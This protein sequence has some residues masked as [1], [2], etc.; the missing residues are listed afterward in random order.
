MEASNHIYVKLGV[1]LMFFI[2]IFYYLSL[3]MNHFGLHK[4]LKTFYKT[5][6]RSQILDMFIPITTTVSLNSTINIT[7]NTTAGKN[8]TSST[9]ISTTTTTG[10]TT[11][12]TT[13]GRPTTID[14]A[15]LL[16]ERL[17]PTSRLTSSDSKGTIAVFL[18]QTQH[19]VLA[20]LQLYL[21]RKFAV[22]LVGLELFL[23]GPI[24]KE[25]SDV[26]KTNKAELYSFP[27]G[28][29][30]NNAGPSDRN[31]DVV[32]WALKKSAKRYLADGAAIL[33][34]DGDVFPLSPFDSLTLLNSR[35][36]VCRKHPALFSRYCW[37]GF[38]CIGPQV[39]STID[40]LDVSQTWRLNRAYDA[41]G[42][43]V[44]YFLKYENASFSWMKETIL[45]KPDKNLFWGAV[46]VDIQWIGRS[47]DRCDKCGPEILFPP[48]SN[49]DAVFYHMISA[50][51][52]WRF[53]N[54]GSRRQALHD[55]V[56]KSPY[57]PDQQYSTTELIASVKNV[58]K[59]DL[60]P[61]FGNLT[62]SRVCHG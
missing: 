15:E 1:L 57:G 13:T 59:M 48:F 43:T 50:T 51:S 5:L 30:K 27:P 17:P 28:Q 22:K 46:D 7:N 11:I 12:T 40:D 23:D 16:V 41:G 24:T 4:T 20:N 52:E 19:H 25:M 34:L 53:G 14:P 37:I 33:L 56:M 32:N 45:L 2:V 31:T 49:S 39:Y 44:E 58:Q 47:F 26:A 9:S 61:Y 8:T 3:Q 55:S 29:H 54:Q 6:N 36:I 42:K 35:D 21:V 60:I 10:K 62:C 38:I 18:F